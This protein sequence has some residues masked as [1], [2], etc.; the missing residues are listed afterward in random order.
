MA[1]LTRE[2]A[3]ED[4]KIAGDCYGHAIE[5]IK[6]AL[7]LLIDGEYFKAKSLLF[8][9]LAADEQEIEWEEVQA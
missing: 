1:E 4:L 6:A 9:A 5:A 3:L 8:Q 7:L 2:Q